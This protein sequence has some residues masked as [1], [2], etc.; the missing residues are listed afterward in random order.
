MPQQAVTIVEHDG[1]TFVTSKSGEV[2]SVE[3]NG[4][5]QDLPATDAAVAGSQYVG[6]LRDLAAI[7]DRYQRRR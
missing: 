7:S 4:F 1:K 3:I 6:D 2:L 5:A